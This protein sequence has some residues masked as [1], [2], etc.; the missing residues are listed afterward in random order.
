MKL[1]LWQTA[2]YLG[3]DET[4]VRGWTK[5]RDLPAHVTGDTLYFNASELWAWAVDKGVS[6]SDGAPDA[7]EIPPLSALL[8]EDGVVYDV[9]G[10]TKH[11]VLAKLIGRL[12]VADKERDLLLEFVEAR[13]ALT[14]TAI[15]GGIAIPHVRKW[16]LMLHPPRPFL[17]LC[18]LRRPI[19]FGAIDGK[20]VHALF[21]VVSPNV[22]M[23][24]H[25]LAR[26]G[27]VLRDS[28]LRE[29]LAARA[30]AALILERVKAVERRDPIESHTG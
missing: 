1:T 26:L 29:M 3:L 22:A 18:L 28:V 10:E 24:L 19:D 15:G 11:E 12:P 6:L 30:S 13:E 14:S 20:P 23:H 25:V 17:G 27:L 9:E 4:T 7:A 5:S 21:L 8:T 16:S 2:A